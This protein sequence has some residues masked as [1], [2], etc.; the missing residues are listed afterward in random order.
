VR[1]EM[2]MRRYEG[3]AR[4][5]KQD[6]EI[7]VD[8]DQTAVRDGGACISVDLV[9]QYSS[10]T[11]T[12]CTPV[13]FRIQSAASLACSLAFQVEQA[14]RTQLDKRDRARRRTQ[15]VDL[16]SAFHATAKSTALFLSS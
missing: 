10:F 1:V 7:S 16:G 9:Y 11:C 15:T 3:Q 6:A 13:S 8:L 2:K 4:E 12:S 5:K 14:L